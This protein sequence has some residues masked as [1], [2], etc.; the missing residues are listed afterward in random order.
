MKKK[1]LLYDAHMHTPLCK[2]AHGTPEDYAAVAQQRGLKGIII[3]CHNP[4]NDGWSPHVRMSLAEFDTYVN[5]VEQA[6]KTWAGQ[7]DIRLGL[8]CDYA[9]GM[10]QWL[11]ELLQ[12]AEFH[13][14]LGSVHPHLEDYKQRFYSG[15]IIA[16]QRLY[17]EHIAMAAETQLFDTIA[18]PDLVKIIEPTAW[19][20]ELLEAAI[21]DSL[22]RIAAVGTVMELNTS[23]LNKIVPEMNPGPIM[24]AEMCRRNIPVI[25][26]SDAH[27]PDRVA[28]DFLEAFLTLEDVGYTDIH[29]VLDRTPQQ[30]TITAAR[31]S[32]RP[33]T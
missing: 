21:H 31:E 20:L 10:E 28:A 32:L 19:N 9:P 15:D 24:L 13:H 25:V 33:N 11:E 1:P 12:M 6:R 3:T 22:D 5:L 16:F 4:T 7:I 30:L 2:H 14:V 26:N 23:G 29:M 17:F 18:H 8:E 27:T